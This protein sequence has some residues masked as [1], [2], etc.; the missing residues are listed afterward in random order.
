MRSLLHP[1][2]SYTG[3]DGKEL[4]GGPDTGV[5]IAQAYAAALPDGTVEV[6]STYVQ[7]NT[8][9]CEAP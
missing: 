4:T 3:G 1:E 5:A 2:Y 9:I 7:G 6:R 8:A